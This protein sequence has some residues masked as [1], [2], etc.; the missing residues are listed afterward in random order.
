MT[1]ELIATIQVFQGEKADVKP[2]DA[3][4]GSKFNETDGIQWVRTTAGWEPDVNYLATIAQN[5]NAIVQGLSQ[6]HRD[7]G[8]VLEAVKRITKRP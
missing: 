6:A 3:T 4:I 8:K 7:S 2:A 1:V 5:T